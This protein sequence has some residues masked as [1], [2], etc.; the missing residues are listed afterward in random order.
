[1]GWEWRH[2][3][4]YLYR[5]RRVNGR[6]VKEYVAADGPVGTLLAL[7]LEA[8]RERRTA[9]R[10][11]A[12]AEQAAGR[13]RVD[14]LLHSAADA[15]A[16]LRAVAEGLLYG[17]GFHRHH[18]GDWRMRRDLADLTTAVRKLKEQLAPAAPLVRYTAPAG[19]AEAVAVFAKA[20]DGDADARQRVAALVRERKWIDWLGDLGRQATHQLIYKAAGGDPVWE[21]GIVEKANALCAELL[22]AA[23]TVLEELLVRRVVNGWVTT[24][25]LELALTLR[26]PPDAR[27]REHLD[28]ALTR[29]QKRFAE[30]ARE[31]ARVRKL[32][33]P[34]VVA[35]LNIA[36]AQTVVAASG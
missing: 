27:G 35:Q 22:G 14:E 21:A 1:M 19:D 17:I 8:E 5:N 24:H 13:A 26:P 12:R 15:N 7:H 3:R 34:T 2:G 25:A 29:A 31:L 9:E 33:T 30:A 11:R 10:E 20:R 4:R 32:Q 6:P 36:A 23:P 28:K 16:D 18:R